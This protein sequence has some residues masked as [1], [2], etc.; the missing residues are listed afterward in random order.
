MKAHVKMVVALAIAMSATAYGAGA[1]VAKSRI[2]YANSIRDTAKAAFEAVKK[3]GQSA[4]EVSSH[5]K[6]QAMAKELGMS[7]KSQLQVAQAILDGKGFLFEALYANAAAKALLQ[8]DPANTP[9]G[10]DEGISSVLKV[11]AK[12]GKGKA[13]NQSLNMTAD[14]IALTSSALKRNAEF[15]VDMLAW[16]KSDAETHI[17]VANR[18]AEVFKAEAHTAEEAMLQAIMDVVTNG[19]RTAAMKIIEKMKDCV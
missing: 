7:E 17:K 3:S 14:E 5:P 10:L 15:T 6:F 2:D 1:E 16:S 9:T 12:S 18:M 19:D 11:A 13:S 4:K 8:S